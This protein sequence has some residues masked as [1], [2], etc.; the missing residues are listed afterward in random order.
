[1]AS[2]SSRVAIQ[3]ED[4]DVSA[5]VGALRAG[6]AGVGA[7]AVFVGTVRPD[8]ADLDPR[9]QRH[10]HATHTPG[11]PNGHVHGASLGVRAAVYFE[12]GGFKAAP[13]HEDVSL[14]DRCRRL[15]GV[16]VAS[17]DAEVLTSGRTVGRTP[18][19]YAG[20]LREQALALDV[21]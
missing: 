9:H 1:M 6:D 5:E 20:Y 10:W 3:A 21:D 14:V 13:E 17:D 18:G 12:A 2:S 19:G 4:F 8:F 16:V 11:V 15:G 7:V